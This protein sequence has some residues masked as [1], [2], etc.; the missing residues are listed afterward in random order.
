MI[1]I[2]VAEYCSACMDFD[3]DVQ[4]PQK[5]YGM[6][7]EIVISDTVIRCSNRNRCKNIERYLRKKVLARLTKQCRECPFVETCEHKE[8]EAL[9]YLPEPIMADVKVP[10]TADIAAPILR[11]TVSR[12]VDGKVVT[13]HKDE[14]EKVLYKDLYSHLGLQFGG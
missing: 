1:T 7:E 12:V 14:L 4:R 9:G 5:A 3:P 8:M 11:E 2:D 13:M 6:S 10:V